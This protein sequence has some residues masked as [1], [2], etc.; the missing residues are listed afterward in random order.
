MT[1]CNTV[2]ALLSDA[3]FIELIQWLVVTFAYVWWAVIIVFYSLLSSNIAIGYRLQSLPI[4]IASL[5]LVYV[6]KLAMQRGNKTLSLLSAL[7]L[8][9]SGALA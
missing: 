3:Q 7:G 5:A 4:I 6:L 9:V 1:K 2:R 8:I